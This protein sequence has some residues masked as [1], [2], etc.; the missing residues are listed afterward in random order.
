LLAGD[1]PCVFSFH[2][3]ERFDGLIVADAS[4]AQGL[5]RL[6]NERRAWLAPLVD[7]TGT[8][9]WYAD[10]HA[11]VATPA[12]LRRGVEH[13]LVVVNALARLPQAVLAVDDPEALL[14]ARICSRGRQLEPRYD[15]AVPDLVR[16]PLAGL[17]ER[18]A[19]AAN[20]LAERGY[21]LRRFFDRLHSCPACG[22]SRLNVREECSACRSADVCDETFVHH[23]A[24][25]HQAMER[26][27]RNGSRLVCPKCRQN[28]RHFG[29]DYDRPGSATVCRACGHVDGEA[30]IGFVCIDCGDRSDAASVPT[31][32]WYSYRLTMSG[33]RRLLVADLRT[34]QL[35]PVAEAE[36]FRILMQHCL[37]IQCRYG[38]P[39]TVLA[40]AFDRAA[41]IGKKEG[42][43]VLARASRQAIEIVR[44]E[45]RSTDTLVE[46]PD[47]MHILLPETDQRSAEVPCQR[48]LGC[49]ASSVAIDLGVRIRVMQPQELISDDGAR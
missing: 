33:E 26:Q 13:A 44:G 47:G 49:I 30:A 7:L 23:Y 43:D 18:P 36:P 48:L 15:A 20:R 6:L 29:V 22:S 38:R 11:E 46:T 41:E 24:C 37:D 8:R 17:I 16:Y 35:A 10:F 12:T 28:L 21:L 45:L 40:I 1:W 32:D 34:P 14:L 31:R 5:D 3:E 27:F 9:L 2:E 39:A 42:P 19:E 25:A 4:V